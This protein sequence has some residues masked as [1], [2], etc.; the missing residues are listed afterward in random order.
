MVDNGTVVHPAL[1]WCHGRRRL[2]GDG[3]ICL[4]RSRAIRLCI[5]VAGYLGLW[6]GAKSGA[7][8]KTPFLTTTAVASL[9]AAP[10]AFAADLPPVL[11]APPAVPQFASWAGPYLGLNVGYGWANDPSVTCTFSDPSPC[12]TTERSFHAPSPKGVLGGVQAGYNW[13]VGTWVISLEGDI[14]AA[15][16][17]DDKYFPSVD[18][19]KNLDRTTAQY[20]WLGTV[21]GRAGYATGQALFYATGGLAFGQ[22]RRSYT[23]DVTGSHTQFFESKQTRTGWTAGAGAEFALDKNVSFKVEYL[24]VQLERSNLNISGLQFNLDQSGTAGST[25]LHF[26]NNLNI[27]RAGVN[28]R[29]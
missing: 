22:V 20:D 26:N 23:Y 29:F 15:N 17:H 9:L 4:E 25:V 21:R 10:S 13:Q 28:V 7:M 19:Q 1:L 5:R 18:P 8:S 12:A 14:S 27:V 6:F 11:K 3:R 24:Y 2:V 16:I